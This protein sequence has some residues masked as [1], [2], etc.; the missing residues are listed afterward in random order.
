MAARRTGRPPGRP[1]GSTG[2]TTKLTQAILAK[3]AA[4]NLT[5]LEVILQNMRRH[6]RARRWAEAQQSAALAAPYMHPRL[7]AATV[8][9]R[10]R[11]VDMSDDELRAFIAEAEAEIGIAPG[12]PV[13]LAT[14]RP[15]GSA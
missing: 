14:V 5:P 12:D 1:K 3:A 8:T 13:P 9:V 6:L 7:A 10:P 2:K 15:K 11:L 4:R